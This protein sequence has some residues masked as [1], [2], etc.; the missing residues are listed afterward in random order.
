MDLLLSGTPS[1]WEEVSPSCTEP[2]DCGPLQGSR[3]SESLHRDPENRSEPRLCLA[4]EV[5]FR[6][7][8]SSPHRYDSTRQL[9]SHSACS[10]VNL[11]ATVLRLKSSLK[12]VSLFRVEDGLAEAASQQGV[13]QEVKTHPPMTT[14]W[15]SMP[16]CFTASCRQ[17]TAPRR[18]W[19]RDEA[20]LWS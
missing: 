9:S 10:W 2:A 11:C 4:D 6:T 16:K 13:R 15:S 19:W 12:S 1:Q 5:L 8:P 14:T 18:S 17:A 7:S 20:L 3:I